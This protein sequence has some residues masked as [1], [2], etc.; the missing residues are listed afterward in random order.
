MKANC[1]VTVQMRSENAKTC[2]LISVTAIPPATH[3]RVSSITTS[4]IETF[5]V[6]AKTGS[7]AH[8]KH[9]GN[10]GKR[11]LVH[12]MEWLAPVGRESH[13]CCEQGCCHDWKMRATK[14]RFANPL[15]SVL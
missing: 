13:R 10:R 4:P 1:C 12:S 9:S 8:C 15:I 11:R 14:L 3:S 6:A 7:M 2:S 5:S